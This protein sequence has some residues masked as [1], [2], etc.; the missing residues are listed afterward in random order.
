MSTNVAVEKTGTENNVGLIRRFTKRVQESGIVK[1]VR[2]I[3]YSDRNRSDYVKKKKT[4]E[5]IIRRT[6]RERLIKLGK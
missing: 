2:G 1:R 3:R 6:E 5:Q 4:L